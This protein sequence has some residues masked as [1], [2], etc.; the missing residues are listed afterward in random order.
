LPQ[1]GQAMSAIEAGAL[2]FFSSKASS[3]WS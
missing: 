1:F 2:P 3:K